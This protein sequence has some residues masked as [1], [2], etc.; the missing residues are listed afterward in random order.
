M[1]EAGMSLSSYK[2]TP[3]I[4]VKDL[5]RAVEFYEG[6]LGLTVA[7]DDDGGSS[8]R[9]YQCGQGSTLFVFVSPEHAGK[10]TAT[11]AGW[12]VDDIER[13]VAEL[14]ARGVF[15]ERYDEPPIVT[16][17]NGIATFD[18]GNK[19]AYFRDPDGNTLSL[20]Q[21]GTPDIGRG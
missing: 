5:E 3:N 19:V 8:S 16:D 2:V 12:Y 1:E 13:L 11:L 10:S 4:A 18:G 20:A 21:P 7:D 17:D 9:G 15:F 6:K 14:T